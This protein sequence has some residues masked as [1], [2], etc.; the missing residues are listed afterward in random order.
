MN[1]EA[2]RGRRLLAAGELAPCCARLCGPIDRHG[3]RS[4][5]SPIASLLTRPTDQQ[6]LLPESLRPTAPALGVRSP[7]SL[8]AHLQPPQLIMQLAPGGCEGRPGRW[9]CSGAW[10]CCPA[11]ATR[12]LHL[13]PPPLAGAPATLSPTSPPWC[14]ARSRPRGCARLWRRAA[15]ACRHRRSP[16]AAAGLRHGQQH[17]VHQGHR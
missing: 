13:Q 8:P 9:C 6:S 10:C 14:H 1:E 12:P 3:G 5:T 7:A 17:A 2:T 15:A 16:R 4:R 11:R